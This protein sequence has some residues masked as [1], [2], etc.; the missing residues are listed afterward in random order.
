VLLREQMLAYLIDPLS[1]LSSPPGLE[2]LEFLE[3]RLGPLLVDDTL[4]DT[5][6]SV[7]NESGQRLSLV[8]RYHLKQTS[9][10]KGHT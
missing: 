7:A 1:H 4:G 8:L 9:L 5:N 2:S 10:V 6:R 3:Y